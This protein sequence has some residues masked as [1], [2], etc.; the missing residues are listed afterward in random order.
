MILATCLFCEFLLFV[1]CFGWIWQFGINYFPVFFLFCLFYFSFGE[2]IFTDLWK[3]EFESYL[4][5]PKNEK[6]TIFKVRTYSLFLVAFQLY[7]LDYHMKRLFCVVALSKPND[8]VSLLQLAAKQALTSLI[9]LQSRKQ[10][11]MDRNSF[12]YLCW[13]DLNLFRNRVCLENQEN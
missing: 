2:W 1:I 9:W 4:Q 5:F 10:S 7:S 3:R 12:Q 13:L 8:H 11:P 6:T